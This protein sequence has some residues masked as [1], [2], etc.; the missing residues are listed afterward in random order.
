M[1]NL[2]NEE[3]QA[4]LDKFGKLVISEV[5]DSSLKVSMDIVKQTTQNKL[6][7]EKYKVFSNLTDEE[8]EKICDLLS[9]TITD[10][11][12]NFLKMIEDY[13]DEMELDLIDGENKYDMKFIS[14][15]MGSEIA[16]YD[17]EGWIQRFSDIGRFV[18]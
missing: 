16:C 17:E 6:D 7:L 4:L 9:A 10:T 14:E 18:L 5:R 11:I 12:Y 13:S 2:N 1:D 3:K 15:E 8:K